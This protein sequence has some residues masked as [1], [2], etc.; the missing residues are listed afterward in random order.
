MKTVQEHLRQADRARLLDS[1]AYDELCDP[2][3]LLECKDM[4]I[5][6]IQ[7]ACKKQ[8]NE[9][10]DHLLSLKV[11]PTDHM[12]LYMVPVSTIDRH[13]NHEFRSVCLIDLNEIRKDIYAASYAFELTE[14]DKN[15]GISRSR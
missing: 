1:L 4:T 3:T 6:E 5:G 15:I 7:N 12:L 13:F 2:I 11:V 9:F 10:I 14:W 8:M